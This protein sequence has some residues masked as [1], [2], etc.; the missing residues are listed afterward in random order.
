MA[1]TGRIVIEI[2]QEEAFHPFMPYVHLYLF[3]LS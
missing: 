1:Q 3:N 2:K